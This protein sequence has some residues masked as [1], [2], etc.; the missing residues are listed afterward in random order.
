[1]Q[2]GEAL[3]YQ[4]DAGVFQLAEIINTTTTDGG[5]TYLVLSLLNSQKQF[6]IYVHSETVTYLI[7]S[8][9]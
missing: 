5:I 7:L 9:Y 3:E 1:M 6:N 8:L 4:D 2:V